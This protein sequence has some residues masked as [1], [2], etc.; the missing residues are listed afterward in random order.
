MSTNSVGILTSVACE[1]QSS[2]SPLILLAKAC[3]QVKSDGPTFTEILSTAPLCHPNQSFHLQKFSLPVIGSSSTLAGIGGLSFKPIRSKSTTTHSDSISENFLPTNK[4][5]I[6]SNS[7]VQQ[8]FK[9]V[10]GKMVPLLNETNQAPLNHVEKTNNV[11]SGK[12]PIVSTAQYYLPA[13]TNISRLDNVNSSCP[14]EKFE[15][16]SQ[17]IGQDMVIQDKSNSKVKIT[18]PPN[19]SPESL[20]QILKLALKAMNEYKTMNKNGPMVITGNVP[21]TASSEKSLKETV[22]TAV[23]SL[24]V[25]A[26]KREKSE[27]KNKRVPCSCPNCI[28]AGRR[29]TS[30]SKGPRIHICHHSGCRKWYTKTSNLRAHLRTHTGERPYV[31]TATNCNKRFNRSDELLRHVRTHTGEKRFSCEECGHGFM[32][33]DHLHQHLKIHRKNAT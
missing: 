13:G 2:S 24:K 25:G 5:S 15:S 31:C 8:E 20:Q 9:I 30:E 29:R 19:T 3:S 23:T 21:V 33:R 32:R 7:G 28:M 12:S 14:T 10:K 22:S 16:T 17:C 1:P 6:D 4:P 26:Q 18:V 27:R 11:L